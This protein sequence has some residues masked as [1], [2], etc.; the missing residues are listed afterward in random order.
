MLADSVSI[1]GVRITT[2][3]LTYPRF[4]HAELMTHRLFS[5]NS[6]SSRAIPTKKLMR[7]IMREPACPVW[8]GKNQAG[9]QAREELSGWR[10]WLAKRGWLAARWGAL[11]AAWVLGALGMHKQIA[12]RLLEPWMFITVIVTAT[13]HDNWFKLRCHP[14]AQPEIGWVAQEM[15]RQHIANTPRFLQ[16]GE[17][18]LPLMDEHDL[19]HID[20]KVNCLVSAGRCARVSY[21][22]H[23]GRRDWNE[24]AGLAEKLMK[25]GHWSPF[26]H[27]AQA[28]GTACGRAKCRVCEKTGMSTA[29]KW[30]GNLRGWLQFRETVDTTFTKVGR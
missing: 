29:N 4:V 13:E 24:D 20:D 8:W 3:E 5:R 18:H 1:N 27:V 14:D 30:S 23:D 28:L 17:W 11:L 10:L 25:S 9:M 26:E 22:T 21:L 12:N 15:Q 6:A 19:Y 16:P 2:W 7:Q